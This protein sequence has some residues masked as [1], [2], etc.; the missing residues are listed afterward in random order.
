MDSTPP[1]I[2]GV[3]RSFVSARGVRFHVTEAGPEHGRPVLLLH[4]WPQ[5]HWVYRDLLAAPPAGLRLI[6]PD[7]PGYGWSGPAPHRWRKED[8]A[9]D[10]LALVDA[11]ALDRLVVVGHDWGGYLGY[12]MLMRKP[13][14]FDGFLVLN[15]A[16]PWVPLRTRLAHLWRFLSYQPLIATCGVVVLRRTHFLKLLFRVGSRLDQH[17]VKVYTERFRDPDVAHTAMQ[18]YRT[19]WLHELFTRQVDTRRVVAP[20]R[21]L[22]GVRDRALHISLAEPPAS[23]ADDCTLKQVDASHFIVDERPSV[24][25]D[26][27][28]ALVDEIANR[29]TQ[30]EGRE[31]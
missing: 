11:L 15:M 3:R 29:Q 23:Q 25:R 2:S 18:T 17:S 7:L 26:E 9:S 14:T 19:F 5:H 22:F 4:G 6:A 16:H 27:L 30:V 10:L 8:V 21:G 31:Q 28:T 1:P 12:L 20:I 13:D 24:V